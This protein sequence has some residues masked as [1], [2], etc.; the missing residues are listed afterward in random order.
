MKPKFTALIHIIILLIPH[1]ASQI[2]IKRI[3]TTV[4]TCIKN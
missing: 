2:T 1:T 3:K 4:G